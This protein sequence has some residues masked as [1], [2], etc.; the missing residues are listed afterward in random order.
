MHFTPYLKIKT[1]INYS[2]SFIIVFGVRNVIKM[3]NYQSTDYPEIYKNVYWGAF[4]F[5]PIEED[6][7]A[8]RNK[9]IKDFNI[10]NSFKKESNSIIEY[11]WKLFTY[12]ILNKNYKFFDHLETYKTNRGYILITSPYHDH[13]NNIELILDCGFK[14]MYNLYSPRATTFYIEYKSLKDLKERTKLCF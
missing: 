2:K 13:N 6:I 14:K 1:I 4:D 7:T 3:R 12:S 10:K 8:N 11:K 9:F 5:D